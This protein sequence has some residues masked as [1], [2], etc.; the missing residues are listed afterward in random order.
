MKK[1]ISPNEEREL[2]SQT[3]SN[4]EMGHL[5]RQ[6]WHPIAISGEL[7]P[8]SAVPVKLFA[9][10]FTLYRGKSGKAYLIAGRCRH[11]STVLHTGWVEDD[12]IRCMYH[13]WKFD[14]TGRC[15][16]RPAEKDE[17]GV[18]A[19]C[20]I[21]GYAVHEYAGLIFAYVGEGPVPEFNL[22]R[23][24]CL[25][26]PGVV[27]AATK[28]TW[29]I[30]WFQQIENSLDPVHVSFVHQTLRVGE[31]GSSV[32]TAIPELSYV[33][34]DAGLEQTATRS[35][36]NIRKSDWTFPNNNH[37]VVPGMQSGD[38]WIDFTI[39]MVPADDTHSTRFTLYALLPKNEDQKR[40]FLD[41]F[42]K[43]GTYNADEHYDELFHQR[44]PPPEED[45]L[46][47]LISAQDY[48]A[49][50]G[51]GVIVDRTKEMLGR[52]D[53]GI[54]TLRRIFVRELQA[55]REKAATKRWRKREHVGE[56]PTP[57]RTRVKAD[58]ANP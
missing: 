53:L 17:K 43:Y 19:R 51:Q 22:P 37:V 55:L 48:I 30:N 5:L 3:A 32:T 29:N 50:R 20:A 23:K 45:Y 11:R 14:G 4:T 27:I 26:K 8:G 16:E 24:D 42:D 2:F 15:T 39:W 57:P 13:G 34:T 44:K 41:Y 56:L 58:V 7:A 9:D 21:P 31:F 36:D 40:R 28:E 25:E 35:P 52:S 6:F 12:E 1:T 33:E 49:Q 54:V 38:P 47:G 10:E 18:P 46:A